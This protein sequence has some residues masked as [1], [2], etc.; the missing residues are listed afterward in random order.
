MSFDSREFEYADTS[1]SILGFDLTG[2]RG[3]RYKKGQEKEAVYGKGNQPRGIQR[4]NKAYSGSLMLLKSD[5][6]ALN[7][8]ARTA[9]YEDISDVPGHLITLTCVYQKPNAVKLSVDSCIN[10]EFT[11]WEDGMSQGDAFKEVTLPF[12][13]LRLKQV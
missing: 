9:G 13:F 10:V 8:A 11:E 2:L 1:V 7:Q 4:K 12:I 6:D 3:I 5:F